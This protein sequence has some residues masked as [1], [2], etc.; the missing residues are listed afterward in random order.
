MFFEILKVGKTY[1]AKGFASSETR[2]C[3]H[4]NNEW[5]GANVLYQVASNITWNCLQS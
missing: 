4:Y 5:I 1:Q 2:F 3:G